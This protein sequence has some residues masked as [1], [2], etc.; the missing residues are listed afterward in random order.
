M[1]LFQTQTREEFCRLYQGIIAGID[2]VFYTDPDDIPLIALYGARGKSMAVEVA[3]KHIL[4]GYNADDTILSG[5]TDHMFLE[6][7][8]G[9]G[10]GKFLPIDG[11]TKEGHHPVTLAFVNQPDVLLELNR[12]RPKPSTATAGTGIDKDGPIP[13][14]HATFAQHAHNQNTPRKGGV[15][16]AN[17]FMPPPG[18]SWIKS[19]ITGLNPTGWDRT[20]F[21]Q[22]ES[23]KLGQS[24]RFI[25]AW[26]QLRQSQEAAPSEIPNDPDMP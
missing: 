3:M 5:E 24:P 26:N 23:P 22:I 9:E 11:H 12:H 14:L 6:T 7:A 10:I 21:I 25:E 8:A 18:H 15:I 2:P 17:S 4:E 13:N 1:G 20:H 16:F 19:M